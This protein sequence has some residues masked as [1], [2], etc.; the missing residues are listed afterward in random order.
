MAH[1]LRQ[2]IYQKKEFLKTKLMLSEFY[3]GR[4]EQLADYTLSELEK[5]YES[6]RKMKKEM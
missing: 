2:A 4:G 3:H 1:L 6:L 5:E